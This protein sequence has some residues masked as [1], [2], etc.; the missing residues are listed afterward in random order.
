MVF[1]VGKLNDHLSGRVINSVYRACLSLLL[2]VYVM[3]ILLFL[4][5]CVGGGGGG[6]VMGAGGGA[7]FEV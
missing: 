6:G 3:Y 4:C 2:S 1:S 5:V 7:R